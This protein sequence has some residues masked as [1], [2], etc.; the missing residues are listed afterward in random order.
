MSNT[1]LYHLVSLGLLIRCQPLCLV[2]FYYRHMGDSAFKTH[3]PLFVCFGTKQDQEQNLHD[4]ITCQLLRFPVC[5]FP[6][7]KDMIAS[8]VLAPRHHFAPA[9]LTVVKTE[10]QKSEGASL[11]D[12][13][14]SSVDLTNES[15]VG[16]LL[17]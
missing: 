8:K 12:K 11:N 3:C 17:S 14:A 6:F 4:L 13:P 16:A 7:L 1:L 15:A 5:L 10:H 2:S 9:K